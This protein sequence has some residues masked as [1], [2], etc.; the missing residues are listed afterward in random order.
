[1]INM[2]EYLSQYKEEIPHW[3][4]NYN[5]GD[6]ISFQN[7]MSGH[8]GYYPGSG[9]DG[10]LVTVGNMSHCVHSF[11]HLDYLLTKE[12]L[13]GYLRDEGFSGYHEIG[14]IEWSEIDIFPN[15]KSHHNITSRESPD[16]FID[17]NA[18]PYYLLKVFERNPDKDDCWGSSRFA[19]AFFMA[20]GIDTYWQLFCRTKSRPPFLFLLQDYGF[21][22]NYDKFGRGGTLSRILLS[23]RSACP[24]FVICATNTT[25]W[26][27]YEE[28]KGVNPTIG[29]MSRHVRCL[30]R[31]V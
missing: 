18:E 21:G 9:N 11:I 14:A 5:P 23:H 28:V 26:D 13:N 2:A 3:L 8:V 15:G 6:F 17:K 20:D 7:F 29:G 22:C 12:E 1:M 25:I 24:E 27:G 19:V 16:V 30:F 31:K 4:R 10:N